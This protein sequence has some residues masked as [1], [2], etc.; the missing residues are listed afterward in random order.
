MSSEPLHAEPAVTP[1]GDDGAFVSAGESAFLYIYYVIRRRRRIWHILLDMYNLYVYADGF[2]MYPH[3]CHGTIRDRY[4]FVQFSRALVDAYVEINAYFNRI[5][6][7]ERISRRYDGNQSII[8]LYHC[9][10]RPHS[11]V[12]IE[13]SHLICAHGLPPKSGQVTFRHTN[14]LQVFWRQHA[15]TSMITYSNY[16]PQHGPEHQ[17]I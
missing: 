5:R 15:S 17:S 16:F 11:T 9:R 7:V 10:A 6:G 13:H 2:P 1:L 12:Y 4:R 14:C 8:S 3:T